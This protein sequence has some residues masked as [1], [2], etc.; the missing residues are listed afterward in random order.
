MVKGRESGI[1]GLNGASTTD[2]WPGSKGHYEPL[3]LQAIEGTKL[4]KLFSIRV[5]TIQNN[6]FTG[7][8]EVGGQLNGPNH[9]GVAPN[10]NE[11]VIPL[12]VKAGNPRQDWRVRAQFY[13]VGA[14][15]EQPLG[16]PTDVVIGRAGSKG[17]GRTAG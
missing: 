16:E 7:T 14:G 17:G 8:L 4:P 5:I 9:G 12:V 1:L 3:W 10:G 6:V 11:V 15:Q 2:S 13:A